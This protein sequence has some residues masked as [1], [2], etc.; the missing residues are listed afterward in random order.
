MDSRF[1]YNMSHPKRGR[2][3]IV[4]NRTFQPGTGMSER[5]GTD[6]DAANLYALFKKLGFEVNLVHNQTRVQM[7]NFTI[8]G[9]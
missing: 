5:S 7:L 2:F 1:V 6:R 8:E 9:K 4:N 3:I